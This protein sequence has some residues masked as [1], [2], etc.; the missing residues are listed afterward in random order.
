[1]KETAA[2]TVEPQEKSPQNSCDIITITELQRYYFPH[3]RV[4]SM[5]ALI[6]RNPSAFPPCFT[7][8]GQKRGKC[9]SRKVVDS[10][11]AKL[12]APGAKL[13]DEMELRKDC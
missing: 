2:A 8:P 11:F 12:T 9:W 13:V 3:L 10:W 1:M 7:F 6:S 5:P 4:T